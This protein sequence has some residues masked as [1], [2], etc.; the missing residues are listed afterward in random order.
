V[1][2][3]RQVTRTVPVVASTLVADLLDSPAPVR[4]VELVR[5]RV[6]VH[7]GTGRSDVPVL[8]VCT[9]EAVRLPASV[10]APVLLHDLSPLQDGRTG[11]RVVR[12]W[13]PPRPRRLTPP[14]Q[15]PPSS[16]VLDDIRPE[17]LIGHG[18]GLTPSGDDVLAG[19][20]VAAH[21]VDHPRLAEWVERTRHALTLR[22]TTAVSR[23]LLQHALQG[24]AVPQL[25][26]YLQ[27]VCG[28][29]ADPEA[30]RD[31]LLAVGHSSGAAL[32][33]G[34]DHVLATSVAPPVAPPVGRER[35]A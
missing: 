7:F 23:G 27:A 22:S 19:A 2:Y 28:G 29:T 34:A 32:A 25:A 18:P 1:A 4:L 15:G 14:R 12:W 26:D 30:A 31:R 33:A 11:W 5:T 6:A 8:C 10:V 16:A 24:W 20:L 13:R 3:G 35:A 21:A 9:P 17:F